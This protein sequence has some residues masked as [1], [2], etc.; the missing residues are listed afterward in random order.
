[1]YFDVLQQGCIGLDKCLPILKE[2]KFGGLISGVYKVED[3]DDNL[4]V[5]LISNIDLHNT[6]TKFWQIEEISIDNIITGTAV[7][8]K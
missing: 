1:M 3:R 5:G 4:Y 2:S 8:I 6:I 7:Q